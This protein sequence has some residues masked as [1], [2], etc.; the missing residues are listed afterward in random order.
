MWKIFISNTVGW[1]KK[2][3]ESVA[4]GKAARVVVICQA[5]EYKCKEHEKKPKMFPSQSFI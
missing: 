5:D 2:E 4:A 1:D 3:T